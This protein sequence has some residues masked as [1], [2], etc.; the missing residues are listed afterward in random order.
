MP[1]IILTQY[2]DGIKMCQILKNSSKIKD[3]DS[4]D[5]TEEVFNSL[6]Q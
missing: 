2:E 6:E 1:D 5:R 3:C 4:E